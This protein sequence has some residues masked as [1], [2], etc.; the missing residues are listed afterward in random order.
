[1]DSS[2]ADRTFASSTMLVVAALQQTHR[3]EVAHRVA[4]HKGL[5]QKDACH[6][7]DNNLH[8]KCNIQSAVLYKSTEL[9][10]GQQQR[11]PAIQTRW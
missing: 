8:S 10:S 2:L 6:D 4:R 9:S 11:Q 7:V 1:M 5:E 3:S